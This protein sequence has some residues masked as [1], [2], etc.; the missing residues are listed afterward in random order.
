MALLEP[1]VFFGSHV[2]QKME[3]DLVKLPW[4]VKIFSIKYFLF[5][6]V[7]LRQ[8]S[9][10]ISL[11]NTDIVDGLYKMSQKWSFKTEPLWL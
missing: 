5:L 10:L 11:T 9:D 8:E 3:I 7:N 1:R 4:L 6:M 2:G